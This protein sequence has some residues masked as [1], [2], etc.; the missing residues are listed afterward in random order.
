[1]INIE[2]GRWKL[3]SDRIADQATLTNKVDGTH[4]SVSL[5]SA[6]SPYALGAMKE[7]DFDRAMEA[8][9]LLP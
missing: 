7:A 1:M 9:E 4:Y 3:R 2:S 8:M 5:S 6:P